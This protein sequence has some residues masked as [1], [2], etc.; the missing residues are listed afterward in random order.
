MR[1]INTGGDVH[2]GIHVNEGPTYVDYRHLSS[3]VLENEHARLRMKRSARRRKRYRNMAVGMVIGAVV[4]IGGLWA[5]NSLDPAWVPILGVAVGIGAFVFS[6]K[7]WGEPT[8]D[9]L[10]VMNGIEEIRQILAYREAGETGSG[11][12]ARR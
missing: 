4:V 8:R 10:N 2:G 5:L 6:I 7:K 9:E 11:R 12:S 1:D 3:D